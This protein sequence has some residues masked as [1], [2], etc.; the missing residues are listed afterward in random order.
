MSNHLAP[1]CSECAPGKRRHCPVC[2][3]TVHPTRGGNIINHWDSE[4]IDLCPMGG[5]PYE[6]AGLGRRRF[7]PTEKRSA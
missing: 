3:Q 7:R 5:R 1:H 2:W 4:G 6:L